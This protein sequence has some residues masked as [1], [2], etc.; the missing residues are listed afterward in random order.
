[1]KENNSNDFDEKLN[2]NINNRDYDS[3]SSKNNIILIDHELNDLY[4]DNLKNTHNK[5]NDEV[6]DNSIQIQN[7]HCKKILEIIE[8]KKMKLNIITQFEP[9]LD[10]K[11]EHVFNY[12]SNW[13]ENRNEY[14]TTLCKNKNNDLQKEYLN[15]NQN[16]LDE[17]TES[18][19]KLLQENHFLT[20]EVSILRDK[21]INLTKENEFLV[22]RLK[23]LED[24]YEKLDT[25]SKSY[26]KEVT[27]FEESLRLVKEKLNRLENEKKIDQQKYEILVEGKIFYL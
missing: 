23:V 22:Q 2:I 3:N 21:N 7:F 12:L 20:E 17:I 6:S 10:W 1:M 27:Q 24:E 13:I 14:Y 9:M 8:K 19:T 4:L 18:N 11:D 15:F 16:Q 5:M 25:L 26:S